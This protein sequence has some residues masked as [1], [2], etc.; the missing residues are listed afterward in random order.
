M[1]MW[2]LADVCTTTTTISVFPLS[3][4]LPVFSSFHLCLTFFNFLQAWFILSSHCLSVNIVLVL[5]LSLLSLLSSLL[6]SLSPHKQIGFSDG[7]DTRSFFHDINSQTHT[8]NWC[9][10]MESV[11][12]H[13][14]VNV[15][16]Y[17]LI[18]VC[19]LFNLVCQWYFGCESEP[20]V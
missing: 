6:I 19:G 20:V 18:C 11:Y 13:I 4:F 7:L 9:N 15:H 1:R 5:C 8:Q 14:N 16:G 3:C 10:L 2:V 12:M 17:V